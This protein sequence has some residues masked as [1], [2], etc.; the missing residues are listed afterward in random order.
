MSLFAPFCG[1]FQCF[2]PTLIKSFRSAVAETPWRAI[3]AEKQSPIQ[4]SKKVVP[5][6]PIFTHYSGISKQF[7]APVGN[8]EQE[9][10]ARRLKKASLCFLRGLLFILRLSHCQ[11]VA[12]QMERGGLAMHPQSE[13]LFSREQQPPRGHRQRVP[14]ERARRKH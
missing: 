2:Q 6:I 12:S 3:P 11:D 5:H 8:F 4:L 10:K 9:N 7:L 13:H 14:F 1:Y